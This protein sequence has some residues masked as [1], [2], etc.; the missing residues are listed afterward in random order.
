MIGNCTQIDT[1]FVMPHFLFD[2]INILPISA[3]SSE[4]H[5]V[6]ICMLF[7]VDTWYG[8]SMKKQEEP[9]VECVRLNLK[10][11]KCFGKGEGDYTK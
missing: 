3:A 1:A 11:Q 8:G 5:E 4:F 9:A 2:E 7:G 6:S 10:R